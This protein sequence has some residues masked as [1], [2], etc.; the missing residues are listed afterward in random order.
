M[1]RSPG[2]GN[3]RRPDLAPVSGAM[4]C[5]PERRRGGAGVGPSARPVRLADPLASALGAGLRAS[6]ER[7][8]RNRGSKCH[9]TMREPMERRQ[10]GGNDRRPKLA[11][12]SGA[13]PCKPL[14]RGRALGRFRSGSGSGASPCANARLSVGLALS[15]VASVGVRLRS[16]VERRR[17]VGPASGRVH[18]RAS[19][20]CELP[21]RQRRV[22]QH[23]D[24][25]LP[26]FRNPLLRAH[27]QRRLYVRS[28]C[29]GERISRGEESRT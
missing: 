20:A 13:M 19:G 23:A 24:W 2:G 9:E 1:E 18:D 17:A 21:V 12:V 8:R 6:V 11:A 27:A 25:H 14:S 15:M 28:Q 29:A 22:G 16:G 10:G 7:Q 4:P 5:G 3:D 26:L